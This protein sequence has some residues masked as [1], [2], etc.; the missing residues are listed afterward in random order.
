MP[1]VT[2]KDVHKTRFVC[3]SNYKHSD[4]MSSQS[5]SKDEL[6]HLLG[7]GLAYANKV[8]TRSYA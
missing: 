3:N 2:K 8:Y 7:V 1:L 6:K 5:M 4:I